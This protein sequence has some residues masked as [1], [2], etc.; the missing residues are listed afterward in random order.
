[1]SVGWDDF[2]VPEFIWT[3]FVLL[4][5]LLIGILRMNRYKN[6][7]YGLVFIWAY[8]GIIQALIC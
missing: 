3:D 1:V 7:A 4:V 6:I 2:S 8:F 5:G